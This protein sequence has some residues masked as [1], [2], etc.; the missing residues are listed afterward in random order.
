M[1][2]NPS[3]PPD[4]NRSQPVGLVPVSQNVP[5]TRDA[6]GPLGEYPG[7]MHDAPDDFGIDLL[8]YWRIFNRRKW[9]I[10][11]IAAA[12]LALGAIYTLMQTPLYTAS[13][14]MQIDRKASKVVERGDIEHSGGR[15]AAFLRTQYQLLQSRTMAERVA[16]TLKFGEGTDF[17][18]PRTISILGWVKSMLKPAPADNRQSAKRAQL[19]KRAAGIIRRN[20]KVRPVKGS[21]LVDITYT[22]PVPGRAMRITNA[23]AD[24][25]IASNLDKRFQANAYAKTFLEDKIKQLKLRLEES[26]ENLLDFAQKAQIVVVQEKS[27]IAENNLAAAN[28]ALGVLISERIKNEQLSKQVQSSTAI[29]LPQFLTNNVISGL[30]AQRKALV[31]EYEEKLETLQTALPKNGAHQ[32]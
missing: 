22:D 7:A 25:F 30:R 21:N 20:F 31:T 6:Y 23:Y 11:G 9:L 18:K 24:A 15:G 32:E 14:R 10:L 17:F 12:C 2:Y 16:S 29:N 8:E 5:T 26:E 13:A 28:A 1:N 27:S 19:E 4:E 3:E